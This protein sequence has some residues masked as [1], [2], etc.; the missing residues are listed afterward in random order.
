MRKKEKA[1]AKYYFLREYNQL[2][3]AMKNFIE[4]LDR[5]PIDYVMAGVALEACRTA[6][7]MAEANKVDELFG[8]AKLEFEFCD[9]D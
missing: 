5:S 3:F 8:A 7:F 4:I 1:N 9:I 6:V 2:Y